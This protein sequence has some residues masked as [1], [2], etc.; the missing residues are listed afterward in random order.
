[1]TDQPRNPLSTSDNPAD[2]IY[3]CQ[4]VLAVVEKATSHLGDDGADQEEAMGYY[5]IISWVR[6]ALI[7]EVERGLTSVDTNVTKL[8]AGS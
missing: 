7:Y 6:E 4:Q 8:E 2:T 1:M 3:H 5:R